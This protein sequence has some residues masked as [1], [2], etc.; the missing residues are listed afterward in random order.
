MTEP[1]R[2]TRISIDLPDEAAEAVSVRLGML[3]FAVE[4]QDGETIARPAP[5]RVRL[6]VYTAEGSE[7][8]VHDALFDEL[9]TLEGRGI[10]VGG[11]R[12]DEVS[13]ADANWRDAWKDHWRPERF[14]SRLLVQPSF[15]PAED[16]E[17]R[18]VVTLDPGR[19]F[20]TGTHASTRLCLL[21]IDAAL[22]AGRVPR[23]VLDVGTGSGILAI[24]A[25]LAW[26]KAEVVATDID[27]E[28]LE[29][30]AENAE[31]NGLSDRIA[32]LPEIPRGE[33]DLVFANIQLDAHIALA[34]T[35]ARAVAPGGDLV[36]AGLLQD[37]GEQAARTLAVHGLDWIA[38]VF[39]ARD[40]IWCAEQLRRPKGR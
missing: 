25:A 30:A 5:G 32:R 27:P 24:A 26:P 18:V 34:R 29:V 9:G 14:G 15:R 13:L 12:V 38:Q 36:L 28:A 19:A 7:P 2:W 10:D 3:G 39:D 37:Q 1:S 22:V 20:G 35:L 17:G 8:T 11:V 21:A 33:F 6:V 31:A 23:R 40:P 4:V 16:A